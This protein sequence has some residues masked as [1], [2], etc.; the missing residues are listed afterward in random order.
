MLVYYKS[1]GNSYESVYFI[2][3]SVYLIVEDVRLLQI[4][5]CFFFTNIYK[6]IKKKNQ[7]L[8]D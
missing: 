2:L 6:V 5:V 8:R 7:N 1:I 4:I 3:E